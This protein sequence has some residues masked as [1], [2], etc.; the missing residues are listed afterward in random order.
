MLRIQIQR[1][2][3]QGMSLFSSYSHLH[4]LPLPSPPGNPGRHLHPGTRCPGSGWHC[5]DPPQGRSNSRRHGRGNCRLWSQGQQLARLP[6]PWNPW[7]IF[8]E[9]WVQAV[10]TT[11]VAYAHWHSLALSVVAGFHGCWLKPGQHRSQE[12]PHVLCWQAHCSL[13][14]DGE[15]SGPTPASEG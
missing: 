1:S 10:N 3:S 7:D 6:W 15:E 12:P 14:R 11:S 8:R 5:A 2:L 9:P 4:R 13:R